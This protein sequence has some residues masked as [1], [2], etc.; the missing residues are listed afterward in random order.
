[1]LIHH[2]KVTAEHLVWVEANA[3]ALTLSDPPNDLR[4]V[5]MRVKKPESCASSA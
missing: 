3:K 1:M 4:V 2:F 5:E